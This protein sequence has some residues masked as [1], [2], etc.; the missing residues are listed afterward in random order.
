MSSKNLL[1]LL[2][3]IT[4]AACAQG[5]RNNDYTPRTAAGAPEA[6]LATDSTATAAANKPITSPDRKVIHTADFNCKVLNVFNATSK[7]EQLVKS[8]GGIVQDSHIENNRSDIHTS[9]YTADSLRQ[10]H[11]YTTTATLTLRVPVTYLDS[12][13][14]AIPGMTS[15]ID[16]RSLKQSDITYKYLANELKNEVGDDKSTSDRAMKLAKKSKDPIEVQE[17][18]TN[19]QEQKINRKMENMQLMDDVTYATVTVVFSQP[20]QVYIQTIVNPD[21]FTSPPFTL[22]CKAALYN[23]WSLVRA[24]AVAIINIWPVLLLLIAGWVAFRKFRPRHIAVIKK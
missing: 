21:Y 13:I 11:T 17:Y 22:Q 16:S 23:G 2:P 7:L 3:L 15:F 8:V 24:F 4:L 18:E 9:Y 12:I 6:V 14:Q 10:T 19:R 5:S 20:E 1:W